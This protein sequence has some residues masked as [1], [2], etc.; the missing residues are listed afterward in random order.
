MDEKR[1]PRLTPPLL[2]AAILLP[3]FFLALYVAGYF[4]LGEHT[5]LSD[6]V[7]STP[8]DVIVRVYPRHWIADIYRPA[9]HL[10]SR[11]R[12]IP[13]HAWSFANEN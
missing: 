12:G 5:E 10:E 11:I 2:I 3:I 8:G 4:W 6:Q 9:A 1:Q 13:V 7:R